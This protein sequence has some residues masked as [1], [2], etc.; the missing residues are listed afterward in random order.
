MNY[1]TKIHKIVYITNPRILFSTSKISGFVPKM[2]KIVTFDFKYFIF[3]RAYSS[4][5]GHDELKKNS[6]VLE[7]TYIFYVDDK[8]LICG[9][10]ALS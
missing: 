1:E 10:K 5:Y 9:K 3:E 8:I 2:V 7:I 6:V 4:D